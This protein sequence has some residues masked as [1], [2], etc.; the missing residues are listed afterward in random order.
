MPYRYLWHAHHRVV[1]EFPKWVVRDLIEV[2]GYC[3]G[4]RYYGASQFTNPGSCPTSFEIE[5]D[6]RQ[7]SLHRIRG[8]AKILYGMYAASLADPNPRYR[9]FVDTVGPRGLKLIDHLSFREV[10]S[11]STEYSVRVGGKVERRRKGESARYSAI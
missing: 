9:E 8:H 3:L 5:R 1:R 4:I 2:A 6:G 10:R 11:S 7:R